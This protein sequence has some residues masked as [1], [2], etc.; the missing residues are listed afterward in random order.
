ML[1]KTTPLYYLGQW[2]A[3]FTHEGTRSLLQKG[4]RVSHGITPCTLGAV[5]MLVYVLVHIQINILD[6]TLHTGRDSTWRMG[7][8]ERGLGH[9][10]IQPQ[11]SLAPLA[12]VTP[13]IMS[14]P[15]KL[16]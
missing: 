6:L 15:S 11:L 10:S 7:D 14:R 16:T 4:D 12:N 5:H 13:R 3:G 1:Q 8:E 2:W 9:K